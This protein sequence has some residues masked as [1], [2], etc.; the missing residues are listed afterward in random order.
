M[1]PREQPPVPV[2][3]TLVIVNHFIIQTT[4]FLNHFST[5]AEEK[6]QKVFHDI[7]RIE[8][9]LVLLESRLHRLE[10][11][12]DL[13]VT[14]VTNSAAGVPAAV[15]AAAAAAPDAT[16]LPALPQLPG[17][18][19]GAA[20][21]PP[22]VT[23]D[24]PPPA[25]VVEAPPIVKCKD[26]PAL[27]GYFRMLRIGAAAQAIKL[28][29]Q[30]EGY[31]PAWLDLPED[32]E[33]PLQTRGGGAAAAAPAPAPAPAPLA[34]PTQAPPLAIMPPPAPAPVPAPAVAP[35]PAQPVAAAPTGGGGGGSGLSLRDCP[36]YGPFFKML[37][38]GVAP[39]A[40]AAKVAA[41]GL[42]PSMLDRDP[43]S[44]SPI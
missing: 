44:P 24:A 13:A 42:D 40:V 33:S 36:H 11:F 25:P 41:A 43:S 2:K 18:A 10:G 6:L 38:V 21:P 1:D 8:T 30:A 23:P 34:L 7:N 35:P 16:S 15:P 39:P 4:R 17:V 14:A 19:G 26:D 31:N 28:K 9:T 20:A 3:K 32:S 22:P 5:L 27:A 29:M 12:D 37:R